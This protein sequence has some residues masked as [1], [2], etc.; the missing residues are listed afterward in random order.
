MEK[1][2]Y[3]NTIVGAI[4]STC[5]M[6]V[7]LIV[8]IESKDGGG[9]ILILLVPAMVLTIISSLQWVRFVKQ[10]VDYRFQEIERADLEQ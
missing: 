10:Y 4:V 8:M 3:K 2:S 6:V 9:K 5:L 1:K 7:S